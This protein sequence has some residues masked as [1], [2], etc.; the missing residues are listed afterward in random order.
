MVWGLVGEKCDFHVSVVGLDHGFWRFAC[1]RLAGDSG[2]F[3]KSPGCCHDAHC[4]RQ[5]HHQSLHV[6]T[7][8]H[9]SMWPLSYQPRRPSSFM[10]C[11]LG[12]RLLG[13][14]LA[15]SGSSAHYFPVDGNFHFEH[16][17]VI[18]SGLTNDCV[19]GETVEASLTPFL[20]LRLVIVL[21][22]TMLLSNHLPQFA[23]QQSDH[24]AAG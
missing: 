23:L 12:C 1:A 22:R 9:D 4:H 20:D 15:A 3:N 18:W 2:G 17:V 10:Q 11:L 5:S 19:G 8:H 16:F 7:S 21:T 14:L 13:F 6:R 24:D